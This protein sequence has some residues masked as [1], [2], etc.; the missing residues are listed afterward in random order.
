MF[1]A[2]TFLYIIR[3]IIGFGFNGRYIVFQPDH[4]EGDRIGPVTRINPE[5]DPV[6]QYIN[7]L[8][9]SLNVE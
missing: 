6:N 2:M 7:E 1:K 4:K 8:N 9:K 3:Y 5:L